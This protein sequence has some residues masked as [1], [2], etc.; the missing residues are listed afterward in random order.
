M[1]EVLP[2]LQGLNHF[3]KELNY[4]V[5][6]PLLLGKAGACK[7]FESNLLSKSEDAEILRKKI[8]GEC[9]PSVKTLNFGG[10]QATNCRYGFLVNSSRSIE[11][12]LDQAQPIKFQYDQ[13]AQVNV[14]KCCW[15]FLQS[16]WLE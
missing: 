13:S 1:P 11:A 6:Q 9:F 16:N 7:N 8:S 15:G 4:P 12:H 14:T 5:N 2:W 3:Q 10:N